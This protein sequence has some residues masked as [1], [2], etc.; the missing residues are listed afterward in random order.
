MPTQ[1]HTTYIYPGPERVVS[2]AGTSMALDGLLGRYGYRSALVVASRS[3]NRKSDAVAKIVDGLGD[4]F[5]G[6]TDDVH[7][8]APVDDVLRVSEFGREIK[9]D[10][11]VSVGGGS[12]I[13]LCKMVHLCLSEDVTEAAQLEPLRS[14][15]LDG[16]LVPARQRPPAVRQI[17]V[18]T[19]LSTAE[20][21]PA[22][23]PIDTATRTKS[24][25]LIRSG[26]PQVLVYD[27][28]VL[29]HT[30]RELLLS[31][32]LR[33]LDHAVNT[34]CAVRPEP[35]ASLLAEKAIQLFVENLP[36]IEAGS[37]ARMAC[38]RASYYTGL[39]QLSVPHGFSHY[40]VHVLAPIAGVSH[41]ALACVLM[42]A[43]ARWLEGAADA[44]YDRL[45]RLLGREDERFHEVLLELLDRLDMPTSLT[46]LGIT[47][48]HID[49]AIPLALKH[50]MI[51]AN[52]L[53][54]IDCAEDLRGI[55][56]L[57]R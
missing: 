30:P 53:R 26:A 51:V 15:V 44:E 5:K 12:V 25:Y 2:G 42:L 20:V 1:S 31:T 24:M 55:L 48:T 38:Q 28:D 9:A 52:N 13:D 7:E 57:A 39:G 33:G 11:V 40:M 4:A 49:E 37:E 29:T 41:S 32:A 21:T 43:Q 17:C 27:P 50:P 16:E 6:L 45:L 34:L 14:S 54:P 23:S 36:R 18:P 3:L 22:A 56:L 19:T 35:L 10:V 46:A 8:H 47:D